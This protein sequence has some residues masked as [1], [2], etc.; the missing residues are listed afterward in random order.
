[1]RIIETV[2]EGERPGQGWHAHG[3]TSKR[4][5]VVHLDRLVRLTLHKRRWRQ[6]ET[7]ITCHSRPSWDVPHSPYGLDVVF[8]VLGAWLLA[9]RGLHHIAWPWSQQHPERPARRTAQ[10]MLYR[11]APHADRWLLGLR[12]VLTDIV[13]PRPLE[14]I[15]PTGGIPPPKGCTHI[16]QRS[17]SAGKLVGAVWIADCGVQ[18]LCISMRRLLGVARRRAAEHLR[19]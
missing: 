6:F 10:R 9:V 12:L 1:M 13:A 11:L 5:W 4:L 16:T 19:Q 18:S 8:Y 14:K 3:W 15:L 7:G 2:F 17:A